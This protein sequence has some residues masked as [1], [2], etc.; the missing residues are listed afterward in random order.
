MGNYRKAACRRIPGNFSAFTLI[1]LLVVIAILAA[2]LLPALAAA[3]RKA[4]KISCLNDMRQW[5]IAQQLYS[6]D[7][8]DMVPADGTT[9]PSNT[10]YGQYQPDNGFTSG[11]ATVLDPI[12]WYNVLPPLAAEHDLQFYAT[13]SGAFQQKYPFPGNDKGSKLWMC[14]AAKADPADSSLFLAGGKWGFFCYVMDIDL[15][16]KSDVKNGVVGNGTLWPNMPKLSSF[17]H[18]ASQV[19]LSEATFSPTLEGNLRNSGT[20]P[21]ARWNY[22]PKRHSKGGMIVFFD[23]HSSYFKYD[24]VFRS[25]PSAVDSREETRNSDIYWNPNRDDTILN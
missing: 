2:M 7:A 1:E 5:G 10:G 8:A 16:L 13:N 21:S 22:F 18:P 9:T 24:Y 14:P 4:Q 11:A 3:K 20:Y 6:G 12:A 17:K 19:M 23:G 15:K 25:P